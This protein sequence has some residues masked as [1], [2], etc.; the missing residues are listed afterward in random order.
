MVCGCKQKWGGGVRNVPPHLLNLRAAR[1]PGLLSGA[2]PL[3]FGQSRR[4]PCCYD[5]LLLPIN[6][7]ASLVL[8]ECVLW[9]GPATR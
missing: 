8:H 4:D 7:P 3:I 5:I 1:A 2:S 9:A 6:E